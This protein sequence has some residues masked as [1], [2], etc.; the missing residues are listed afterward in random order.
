M[1]KKIKNE[2]MINTICLKKELPNDN[3]SLEI[4]KSVTSPQIIKEITIK[5]NL[6]RYSFEPEIKLLKIIVN[7]FY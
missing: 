1:N 3:G 2:K 7:Y 4:L 5:Y 6:P